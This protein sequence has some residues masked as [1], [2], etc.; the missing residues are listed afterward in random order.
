MAQDLLIQHHLQ[1]L[2][3]PAMAR[4]YQ[5]P[6]Q[7]AA[8]HNWAYEVYLLSLLNWRWPSGKRTS[9]NGASPRP[10]FLT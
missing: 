9:R 10:A 8:Q 1:R 6:A 2:K 7:E 4:Q 3:L 5:K